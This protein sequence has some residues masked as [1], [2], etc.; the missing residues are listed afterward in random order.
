MFNDLSPCPKFEADLISFWERIFTHVLYILLHCQKCSEN[1]NF[2]LLESNTLVSYLRF[3]HVVAWVSYSNI[4]LISRI[5]FFSEFIFENFLIPY[6]HKPLSTANPK[7]HKVYGTWTRIRRRLW[8]ISSFR[9]HRKFKFF[10]VLWSKNTE[11]FGIFPFENDCLPK[12]T[13]ITD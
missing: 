7:H 11:I 1:D 13:E 10:S 3:E 6:L 9:I 12:E 8:Y 4:P 2:S 5:S